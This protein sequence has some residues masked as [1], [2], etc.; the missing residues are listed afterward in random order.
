MVQVGATYQPD[1][2]KKAVYEKKY[3]SYLATIE[4][5]SPLWKRLG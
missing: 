2:G 1:P 4:T 3:Q 5:L